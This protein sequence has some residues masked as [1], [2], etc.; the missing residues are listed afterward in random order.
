MVGA[1]LTRAGSGLGAPSRRQDRA[2]A[3][4]RREPSMRLSHRR[5]PGPARR[6]RGVSATGGCRP[7]DSGARS[8]CAS[9]SELGRGVRP[10]RPGGGAEPSADR[11]RR[12]SRGDGGGTGHRRRAAGLPGPGSR[13]NRPPHPSLWLGPPDHAGDQEYRAPLHGRFDLVM[14]LHPFRP[15]EAAEMLPTPSPADRALVYG[16]PL[17]PSW[18]RR[19]AS[20]RDNLMRLACTPDGRMLVEGG[21]GP[22]HRGPR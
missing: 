14:Q 19:D 17:Y 10:R 4:V 6:T 12:V 3:A 8:P 20:A 7:P 5:E 9:L 2:P 21:P 11:R 18:W 22:R 1:G 13:T 16:M 15:H